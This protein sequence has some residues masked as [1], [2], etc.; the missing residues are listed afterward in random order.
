M[1]NHTK[2]GLERI[3]DGYD[4]EDEKR[5]WFLAWENEIARLARSVG[6]S[7]ALGAPGEPTISESSVH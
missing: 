1:L 2:Q 7:V 5:A 4:L 3:Y 6:V